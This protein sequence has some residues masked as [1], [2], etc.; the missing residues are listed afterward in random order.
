MRRV[1]ALAEGVL[2][3]VVERRQSARKELAIDDALGKPVD[4]AKTELPAELIDPLADQALV[5]RSE[6][7]QAVAHDDPVGEAAVHQAAL[8][9]RLAHHLRV[10]ADPGQHEAR[11][12][13]RAEHVEIDEAVVERRDQR[14]GHRMR[15]PHEVGIGA[16]R[17]DDHEIMGALDRAHRLGEGAEFLRFDL[18]KAQAAT[19]CDA[20]MRGELELDARARRPVAAIVE[21]VGKAALAGIE[22]DRGDA[23]AGLQQ[24]DRNMH[25]RGRL[26][27]TAFF[28]AK[29]DD[30]RRYR[31]ADI[32]LHQHG[33]ATS[34]WRS[35]LR[36]ATLNVKIQH[37][38]RQVN[39]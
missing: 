25:G 5:A 6:R 31:R 20:I 32:R 14:V 28:V 27:G 10:M 12:I 4:G 38:P 9:P 22:I 1:R 24:R 34:A 36:L 19:A 11:R 39:H 8:A 30:M 13:D 18:V 21:V 7:R 15:E 35:V 2:V 37:R 16:R 3:D 33:Y 23:L 26:S 17:I 29:D